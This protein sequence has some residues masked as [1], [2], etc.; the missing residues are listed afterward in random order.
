MVCPG[1]HAMSTKLSPGLVNFLIMVG[2]SVIVEPSNFK[3]FYLKM[4]CYKEIVVGSFS[5]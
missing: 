4:Y 2:T 5:E 1:P 3:E